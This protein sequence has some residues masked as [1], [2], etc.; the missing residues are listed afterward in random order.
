M[1]IYLKN[2]WVLFILKMSGSRG[3]LC[4][5]SWN[6]KML[7]IFGVSREE[8]NAGVERERETETEREIGSCN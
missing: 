8:Q 3:S 4:I 6:V 7:D 2:N 5:R 1:W